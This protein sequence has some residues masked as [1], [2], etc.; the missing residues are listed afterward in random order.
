MTE[1]PRGKL[2]IYMGYAAGV[3]KT[4]KMLEQAQEIRASGTDVVIGYF[5][6]HGRAD[7][8]A[9]TAGLEVVGRKRIEYRGTVFEEMDTDAILGRDPAVCVV[10]EFPH[11][12]VPGSERAKRWQDVEVLRDQGIDVLTTM[13]IQHLEGLNDQVWHITGVRVRETIPDW[14]VRN[15]DEVIMVDVTPRALLHRLERGVIYGREKA[16]HAMQNFFRESSLVALR[17]LTLR[18]TAHEVEHRNEATEQ[19]RSSYTRFRALQRKYHKIL[20]FVS[21]DATTAIAIRRARRVGDY[22]GADCFAAASVTRGGLTTLRPAERASIERHLNFAR[23]L[24]IET[25]VLE[26]DH[27]ARELIDF[28]RRNGVTQLYITRPERPSTGFFS[29]RNT[30]SEIISEA[31]DLQIIIVSAR[32]PLTRN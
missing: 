25:R 1:Q 12:N 14:V 16:A 23:N 24:H 5:E 31:T 28:A 17:E 22:L 30:I 13:N 4:Y 10:D 9:R 26:S 3:G 27:P 29:R 2:K 32:E 8:I 7:T 15:A 18:E 21:A 6:S 11:T 19:A 20:A